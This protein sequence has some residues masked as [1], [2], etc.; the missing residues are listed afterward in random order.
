[1]SGHYIAGVVGKTLRDHSLWSWL[2]KRFAGRGTRAYGYAFSGSGT[3]LPVFTDIFAAS[4]I[5]TTPTLISSAVRPS[6]GLR[7]LSELTMWAIGSE[8]SGGRGS[9]VSA[10]DDRPAR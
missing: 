4:M 7:A 9:S 2:S 6:S 3:A 5:S 8:R 1:M 10:S